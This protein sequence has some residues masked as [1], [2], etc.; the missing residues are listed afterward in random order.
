MVPVNHKLREFKMAQ[1]VKNNSFT[2]GCELFR[3][4]VLQPIAQKSDKSIFSAY[5]VDMDFMT[6]K[7]WQTT[8]A[9]S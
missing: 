6:T 8:L 5:C 1:D 3:S 4:K 9:S 7:Y 2:V